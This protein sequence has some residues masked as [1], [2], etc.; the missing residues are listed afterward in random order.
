MGLEITRVFRR[1]LAFAVIPVA[2]CTPSHPRSI[3]RSPVR[4]GFVLADLSGE[5]Y[6][7]DR[8]SFLQAAKERGAGVTSAC[9]DNRTLRETERVTHLLA[10]GVDVLVVQP[11]NSEDA[12]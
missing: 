9:S 3:P 4:I 11:V 5:R 7:Q 2:A 10:Q 6:A 12:D 1:L 8:D